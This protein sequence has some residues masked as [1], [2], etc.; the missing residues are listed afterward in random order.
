MSIPVS[1]VV[2][3]KIYVTPTF[4]KRK[5]FGLLNIIG[6]S[7][8]LTTAERIRFYSSMDGVAAD[9][10]AS[11]EEYKAATVFFSQSPG[12]NELAI[13]RRFLTAVAGQLYGSTTISQTI[14]AFN[15]IVNGGFDI[16]IDGVL[17]QVTALNLS[18]AANLN[19]V[20]AAVQAKLAALLAGT[21]CVWSGTRFVI[22]S[23]TTGATSTV[24]FATA[25]T[26]AGSP[27][28]VSALLGILAAD[29]GFIAPGVA[30]ET[31]TASLDAIQ[32][33]DA[34]WYGFVMTN[35][36]TDQNIKDC[37]AWAEARVK[38]YGYTSKNSDIQD[39]VVTSDIATFFKNNL[40]RRTIGIFDNDDAYSVVSALARGFV[41]DFNEQNSTLSLKFKQL[42][43]TTPT[44]IT[45]TQRLALTKKNINY[46]SYF[47]DS[48]MLAEGVMASGAFF[49]EVHG[50]DW[51]QNAIETNVF[52][53]LYTRTTKV[54]QTDKGVA[55]I[56]QQV[57]KALQQGV[58]NALLAPGVWNGG[59]LGV[60]KSG[61]FLPK[62]FYVYATSVRVQNQSDREARKAPPIQVIAKGAG[63]I[64]FVDIS[65]TFE[66]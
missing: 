33:A 51:L 46:Y 2:N 41:V 42:P 1:K 54:P 10:S 7:P 66:R 13:S 48:A 34:S 26:G 50:L 28:D 35:E 39:G 8:R 15:A 9:F 30:A 11:D 18:A 45:E 20:A 44:S 58:N 12:P 24:V 63:A 14:G 29:L 65:V 64:H 23:G 5:G 17:R 56:V 25:P 3:V 55:A 31:V 47:G 6:T 32:L 52:G 59:D 36:A 21:T 22:T 60:Y 61:D 62:G 57:E 16:L 19:A 53:F 38:I 27:V 37:A 49:D 40:Y 4:P 43:A